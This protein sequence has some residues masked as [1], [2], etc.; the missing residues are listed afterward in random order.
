[1][2]H[3]RVKQIVKQVLKENKYVEYVQDLI[4]DLNPAE[5]KA[6][7][8]FY[9]PSSPAKGNTTVLKKTLVSPVGRKAFEELSKTPKEFKILFDQE[10]GETMLRENKSLPFELAS[11]FVS[12][13]RKYSSLNP[14]IASKAFQA[15]VKHV[16]K[17]D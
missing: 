9:E 4:C 14:E 10:Y 15:A 1:M 5:V 3:N 2:N 12:V 6:V 16:W 13:M 11:E 7:R 17:E 8:G